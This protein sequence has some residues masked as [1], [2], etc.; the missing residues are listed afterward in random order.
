[1]DLCIETI[2]DT[3]NDGTQYAILEEA[4]HVYDFLVGLNPK[5]DNVCGR[6]LG[7]RPLPSLMEVCFEVCLEED[8]T[9]AMGVLTTPTIDS[10][11]FSTRSS[12]HDSD[13]NNGKSIPMCEHCKKQWHTKDQYYPASTSQPT[14]PTASQTKTPTL[15][16]IAQ[17]G[18]PQSLGLISVDGKNP[19]ILDSG[20]TD[21]LT[22]SS[23]HFISY[24]LCAGNEKS[25]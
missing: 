9:N 23:E 7:Q 24:A 1:M 10:A 2:W 17:S 8:R 4:D 13:K 3:P 6:I 11:A 16:A 14:D 20:A 5:F 25:E 15:G 18:M 12:N 22:D 21:H 19:W